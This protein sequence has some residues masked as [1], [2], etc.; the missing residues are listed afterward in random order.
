MHLLGWKLCEVGTVSVCSFIYFYWRILAL[1]HCV[2]LCHTSAW[3]NHRDTYVPALLNAPPISHLIAPSRLSQSTGLSSE[4]FA[5][6][7]HSKVPL[8]N[9]FTYGYVCFHAILSTHSSL[10]FPHWAHNPVLLCL[11]LHGCPANRVIITILLRL[12][13]HALICN[14][15]PF[16]SDLL[17][18]VLA[19]VALHSSTSRTDSNMSFFIT[20]VIFHC[21]YVPQFLYPFMC[22]WTPRWA[23]RPS[24]CKKCCNEHWGTWVSLHDGFLRVYG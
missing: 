24:Y 18:S 1:Q 8:V 3:T 7:S 13:M 20:W 5:G 16:L 10:S 12:H 11:H 17:H 6:L 15:C 4:T 9:Y 23:L 2:D 19:L 14:T 22:Q 21:T